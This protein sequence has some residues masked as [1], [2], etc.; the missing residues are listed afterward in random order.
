MMRLSFPQPSRQPRWLP[1]WRRSLRYH[2]LRLMRSHSSTES[3]ARGLGAGVFA[4]MLPLFGGQ[5]LIA[6]T[7]ALLVRG[8]KPLAALATWVSNPFTYVPLFWFNFQVGWWLMGQPALSFGEWQSWEKLLEQGGQM[9]TILIFGSVWV[10]VIAGLLTYA[11]CLRLLPTLRQRFRRR[12]AMAAVN[13]LNR[14]QP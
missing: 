9:A 12:S 5:I 7:V 4:G 14:P 1:S 13:F 11:L 8:N 3:I 10:G 2:Y 6:V